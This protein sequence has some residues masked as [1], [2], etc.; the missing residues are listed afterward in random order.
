MVEVQMKKIV[1]AGLKE[2]S[3]PTRFGSDRI[4]HSGVDPFTALSGFTP[5]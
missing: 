2:C 4:K 5:Q 3:E 1:S